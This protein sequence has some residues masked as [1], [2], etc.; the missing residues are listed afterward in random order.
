MKEH[1]Y[2]VEIEW[3]GNQGSG[4]F[5]YRSYSR[6]HI[7]S[8]AGKEHTIKASTDPQF[9]GE[10]KYY[11]P[12]ELLLSAVSSCHMLWYLSLCA[13]EGIVVTAYKDKVEGTL[14]KVDGTTKMTKI[15]LN[16]EVV[17]TD[18]SRIED[19]EKLHHTANELC[20]IANT[21]NVKVHHEPQIKIK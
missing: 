2:D 12:E 18:A 16:P 3:T 6:S 1:K 5:D 15:T 10:E 14:G 13:K 20:F 4:T 17:I 7:I 11:N 21:L 9:L 8:V 19:A